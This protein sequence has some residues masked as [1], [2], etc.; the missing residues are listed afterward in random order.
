M[1]VRRSLGVAQWK[2]KSF[3]NRSSQVRFRY[4]YRLNYQHMRHQNHQCSRQGKCAKWV[5]LGV[6]KIGKCEPVLCGH[7]FKTFQRKSRIFQTELK[8]Q[9]SHFKSKREFK[10]GTLLHKNSLLHISVNLQAAQQL[11]Q[12]FGNLTFFQKSFITLIPASN[13]ER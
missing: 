12:L 8:Q 13:Y 4:F 9:K 10:S 11:S 1:Q 5:Q 7:Y 2:T 3:P 6:S